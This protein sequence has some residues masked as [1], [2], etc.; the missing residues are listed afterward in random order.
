MNYGET[1]VVLCRDATN[2]GRRAAAAVARTMRRLLAR[3][4][5]VRIVFAAAES[6]VPFLDAL[7]EERSIDWKRVT[8]F[9]MDDFWEPRMPMSL[10][11]GA[12]TQKHLYN[13]A[14]PAARHLIRSRAADPEAEAR[15]FEKLLREAP[16]DITCQGIGRSGHIALN[17]PG[18]TDFMDKRWVRV[19]RIV[20]ASR[21]QLMDDPHFRK[22]GR[23]PKKGITMT[24]PALL[25]ARYIFTMV[26][27]ASKRPILTRLFR[28]KSVTPQLPASI[29]RSVRGT[30]FVDRD[31]CP[32][33]ILRQSKKHRARS[34]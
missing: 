27:L 28:A 24:L 20:E 11:C 1:K 21:R 14:R 26:P 17:E 7:A 13:K 19:V 9:N 30:L 12:L 32:K 22:L 8:C 15:R 3:Q 33:N 18:Q 4:S 34:Q 6:Q 16:I 10:T 2:L 25:S 5:E 29:L 23:I 31:S